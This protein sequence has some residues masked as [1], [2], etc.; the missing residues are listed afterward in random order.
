MVLGVGGFFLRTRSLDTLSI[1]CCLNE[2]IYAGFGGKV[3]QLAPEQCIN[4]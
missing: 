4:R 3:G 2:Q 1:I